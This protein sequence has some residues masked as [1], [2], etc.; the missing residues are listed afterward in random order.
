[1]NA[2]VFNVEPAAVKAHHFGNIGTGDVNVK[3]AHRVALLGQR[4]RKPGGDGGFPNAALTR[5][6]HDLV[7]D[8]ATDFLHGHL[9][10]H[11]SIR[12]FHLLLLLRGWAGRCFV[13][14]A[15]GVDGYRGIR[16]DATT[17]LAYFNPPTRGNDT[18]HHADHRWSATP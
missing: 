18:A 17:K 16:H 5:Q 4:E 8:L 11:L 13:C 15:R 3:D 7:F 14:P 2:L 1:M 9:P 6:D 10:L 12:L